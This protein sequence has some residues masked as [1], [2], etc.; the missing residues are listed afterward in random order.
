M[1]RTMNG[2]EQIL[3][4][5]EEGRWREGGETEEGKEMSKRVGTRKE[6]HILISVNLL[7]DKNP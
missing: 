7:K 3:S 1:F 4:S 5:S 6:N 2:G